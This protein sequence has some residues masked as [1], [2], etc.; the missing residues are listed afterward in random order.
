MEYYSAIKR[1]KNAICR[2]MDVTREYH[3][4]WSKSEREKQITYD[5]T[6]MWNLKYDTYELI[7]ERETDSH[8][9]QTCSAKAEAMWGRGKD[10]ESGVSRDKLSYIGWINNKVI[11]Y[12]KRNCIQY[13]T[14][15]RSGKEYEKNIYRCNWITLLYSKLTQDYKSTI[16]QQKRKENNEKSYQ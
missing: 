8:R 7:Y 2:N 6:Y 3:T 4:K 10:L 13:P 14:I 12:S 16:L 11:L 15:N 1:T 5:I 9:E